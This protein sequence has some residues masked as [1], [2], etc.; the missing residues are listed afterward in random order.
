[1]VPGFRGISLAP[2]DLLLWIQR[3]LH[4]LTGE[5]EKGG[6]AHFMMVSKQK[7]T[8][9]RDNNKVYLSRECDLLPLCCL[10]LVV[11]LIISGIN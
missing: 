1:M 10:F 9:G 8:G 5:H 2:A 7:G 3:K 6:A 11:N 4:T